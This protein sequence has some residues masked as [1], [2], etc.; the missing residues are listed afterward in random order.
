MGENVRPEK[1]QNIMA[2]WQ[3][4]LKTECGSLPTGNLGLATTP[5]GM[6]P[7][8]EKSPAWDHVIEGNVLHDTRTSIKYIEIRHEMGEMGPWN[9][10]DQ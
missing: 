7:C 10:Y 1:L 2:T 3:K 6:L 5:R 8:Q 9:S 4:L